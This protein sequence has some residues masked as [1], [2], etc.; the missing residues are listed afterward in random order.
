M[1][2]YKYKK[3]LLVLLSFIFFHGSST[4]KG[5]VLSIQYGENKLMFDSVEMKTA[6]SGIDFDIITYR[7]DK[8]RTIGEH[9]DRIEKIIGKY[10]DSEHQQPVFLLSDRMSSFVGLDVVSKD[11]TIVGLITLSGAFSDG[12]DFLYDNISMEKNMETID[13]ISL[14]HSKELYLEGIYNMIHDK[15]QGKK[16]KLTRNADVS[17]RELRD[18]LDSQYG[19]S[20]VDFSLEKRLSRIKSW[21][22]PIIYDPET[23]MW[24]IDLMNLSFIGNMYH[25]RH[26]QPIILTKER[27]VSEVIKQISELTKNNL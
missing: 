22:V 4:A 17:A 14:D 20:L 6:L 24:S 8:S 3:I 12:V 16:V 10:H 2:S 18:L 23:L 7:V 1:T 19:T 27:V 21:I 26:T 13:S 25:L 9:T 5:V 11:T 15:K